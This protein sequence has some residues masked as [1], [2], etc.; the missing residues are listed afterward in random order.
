MRNVSST[1]QH[2][3]DDY[4]QGVYCDFI[5]FKDRAVFRCYLIYSFILPKVCIGFCLIFSFI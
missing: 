4:R 5:T 3:L 2:S 1:E